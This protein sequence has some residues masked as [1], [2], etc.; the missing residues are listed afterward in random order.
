MR[1]KEKK[2]NGFMRIAILTAVLLVLTTITGIVMFRVYINNLSDKKSGSDYKLYYA[3][4]V[5][6]RE[7]AF[8]KSVYEGAYEEGLKQGVYIELF[9]TNAFR[10]KSKEE[11]LQI[12]VAAGV[13]GIILEADESEEMAVLI[14]RAVEE[15]IPVV[16]VYGD[17][18]NSERC[19]YIGVG[20]YD[21]GQ[22][23]GKQV[24]TIAG[25]LHRA[26]NV[27][28]LMSENAKSS[29]Q[30]T[31][32]SGIQDVVNQE[33][34]K[35]AQIALSMVS[36]DDSNAFSAEEAIRDIF[37]LSDLPDII[38]CLNERNTNC[39]YQTVVDYNK[40]GQV[41]ILGYYDSDSIIKAIEREVIHATIAVD[42]K[43]MGKYC[44]EAL[45]EYYHRGY[46]SQYF[47][48]DIKLINRNNVAE[49]LE[50]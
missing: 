31:L 33:R 8:W 37:T 38:I 29:G 22:E 2:R 24:L 47:S 10:N 50:K 36:V 26:V 27:T 16:T 5:D 6:E 11:L 17:N 28:V 9:G 30:N 21:I 49:Y 42:T 32:F 35:G 3:M 46:T 13:D 12:A 45:Q 14:D 23:Y 7:S 18:A 34:K 15:G 4:I 41:Q 1:E 43:Q 20:N 44:V 40:V 39:V 48:V 25:N 19:S